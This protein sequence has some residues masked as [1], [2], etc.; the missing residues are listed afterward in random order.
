MLPDFPSIKSELK[1]NFLEILRLSEQ[2]YSF[3]LSEIG[4]RKI[5]EGNKHSI[6]SESGEVKIS[7]IKP[8]KTSIEIPKE[9]FENLTPEAIINKIDEAG[10]KIADQK[11]VFLFEGIKS[12]TEEVGNTLDLK[13]RKFSIDDFFSMLDQMW[14][15]FDEEGKP[16]LPTIVISPSLADSIQKE[17]IKLEKDPDTKDRFTEI[18][19]RKKRE[20]LERENSR[21]LV[22]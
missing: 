3:I 2:K 12:A 17:M 13:G 15:D 14:I 21:K 5:M 1:K 9:L 7:P 18:I 10:Q 11:S 8:I 16:Y 19:K 6:V 20:W 4:Q 22:G